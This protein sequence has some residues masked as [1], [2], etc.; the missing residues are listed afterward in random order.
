[1]PKVFVYFAA[2]G[3]NPHLVRVVYW[4]G[5]RLR[6]EDGHPCPELRS[7]E[8]RFPCALASGLRSVTSHAKDGT[9][10]ATL[11]VPAPYQPAVVIRSNNGTEFRGRWTG[12]SIVGAEG[13]PDFHYLGLLAALC[14]ATARGEDQV[15]TAFARGAEYQ[16]RIMWDERP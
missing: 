3:D 16:A 12:D 14:S 8:E 7:L 10:I 1:M 15:T 9:W 13:I 4:D 2:K 11:D 6:N 5:T